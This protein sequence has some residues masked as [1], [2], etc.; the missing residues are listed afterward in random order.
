MNNIHKV[1]LLC[2]FLLPGLAACDKTVTVSDIGA[3]LLSLDVKSSTPIE[4]SVLN[5]MLANSREAWAKDPLTIIRRLTN[6]GRDREA[7][8]AFQGPGEYPTYYKFVAI[9]N[10]YLDD[11]IQGERYDIELEQ[12]AS[13]NWRIISAAKSWRCWPE[14]GHENYSIE[15]CS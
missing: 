11:S 8:I 3:E 6:L 9:S 1:Y 14:R 15:P 2:F 13:Q 12:D 10:G 7:V 4:F 5:K